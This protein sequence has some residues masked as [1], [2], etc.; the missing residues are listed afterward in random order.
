MSILTV[1]ELDALEREIDQINQECDWRDP[2]IE[3][4][5]FDWASQRTSQ[6]IQILETSLYNLRRRKLRVLK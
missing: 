3:A 6:I 4:A 1:K 2:N 5:W